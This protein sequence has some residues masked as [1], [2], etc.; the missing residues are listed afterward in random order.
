MGF[1]P[2]NA[3]LSIFTNLIC[4]LNSQKKDESLPAGN[5][6]FGGDLAVVAK[7]V[8][9]AIAR[10]RIARGQTRQFNESILA[11]GP[12]CANLKRFPFHGT[13]CIKSKNTGGIGAEAF[14]YTLIFGYWSLVFEVFLVFGVWFLVFLLGLPIHSTST[15]A[16]TCV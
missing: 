3:N 7:R 8:K 16:D 6:T 4:S 14:Q 12:Q 5:T 11:T 9:S 13:R 15:P 1:C 10:P 2:T